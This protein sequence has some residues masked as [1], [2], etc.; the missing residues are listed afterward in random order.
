LF[1]NKV[2]NSSHT[3]LELKTSEKESPRKIIFR[4]NLI[5]GQRRRVPTILK[6]NLLVKSPDKKSISNK[7]RFLLSKKRPPFG[8]KLN[9]KALDLESKEKKDSESKEIKNVVQKKLKEEKEGDNEVIEQM[10]KMEIMKQEEI[11][12]TTP[13]TPDQAITTTK[14]IEDNSDDLSE[15]VTDASEDFETT[16]SIATSISTSEA[17]SYFSSVPINPI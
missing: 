14:D 4:K 3:E 13:M 16:T 7:S 5:R 17:F 8:F 1:R 11:T 2:S 10:E 15:M 12:A 9:N 6:S